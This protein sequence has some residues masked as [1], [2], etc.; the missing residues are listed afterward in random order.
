MT[1]PML[2]VEQALE[3]ILREFHPL[4]PE[5][6]PILE[7]LGRVLGADIPPHANSLMERLRD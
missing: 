1:Q 4:E 5:R 2:T 7:S 6:A 3:R